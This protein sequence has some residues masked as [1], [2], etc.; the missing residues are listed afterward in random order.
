[1]KSTSTL[2]VLAAVMMTSA[3][4]RAQARSTPGKVTLPLAHWRSLQQKSEP[5]A[6]NAPP[7]P[8]TCM[9][10]TLEGVFGRGLLSATLTV[11][12]TVL[13]NSGH[14]WVPV[15]DGA[16]FPR[17]VRLDGK[18]ATLVR[19][20][21]MYAV[22]V[23]RPGSY[24]LQL[25]LLVGR[26]QD[27][28]ARRLLLRLPPGCP[29]RLSILVPERGIEAWLRRGALSAH[30]D[31]GAS[32]L[33]RGHLDASGK[34][35][36]SWTRKLRV[37][38]GSRA[39]RVQVHQDTLLTVHE[40]LVN[41]VAVFQFKVLDGETDRFDLVLPPS[42]EVTRVSGDAVLQWQTRSTPGPGARTSLV[43]LL[44][45]LVKGNARVRVHYSFPAHPTRP[46]PLAMITPA[47][48]VPATG[49]LGVQAPA[50]LNVK[51]VRVAHARPLPLR[52]LP[53]RLTGLTRSP[54]IMGF[55]FSREPRLT[56]SVTRNR[57]VQ[58]T[59]T[60]IDEVQAATVITGEGV[61]HTK[62]KLFIRNNTRQYLGLRL[63]AGASLLGALMDGQPVHP[64]RAEDGTLLMPLRQSERVDP[65]AGRI[66]RV[67]PGQTLGDIAH[68]YYSDPARWPLILAR[69]RDV[70]SDEQ[71]LR[72]GQ[73]LKIPSSGP[74]KVEEI[75]A[76]F[77]IRRRLRV[78]VGLCDE[79]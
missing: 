3:V 68:F 21:G 54:L 25:R 37:A 67:T 64:A 78:R 4:V 79:V 75:R 61:E 5:A 40:S 34:L 55:A 20:Q 71:S 8:L 28:F 7:V 59:T 31:R 63:P 35:E 22:G 44:R 42:E 26:Q 32:T 6:A 39:A 19:R 51:V 60:L 48:K 18:P 77:S 41:G 62:L 65:V 45:Y 76:Q 33:L 43:V 47:G 56:L 17:Q 53:A 46:V 30:L 12:L 70:L 74:V 36:L 58:L 24:L 38:Q 27:R 29:T 1:M 49:T 14:V 10:R 73:R 11:R 52:D 2:Y 16:A 69:N 9:E 57:R 50:G 23:E 15:V 13:D 72:S 66:H